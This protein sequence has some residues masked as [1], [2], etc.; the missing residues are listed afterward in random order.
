[1]AF[2]VPA[3]PQTCSTRPAIRVRL[4]CSG[5]VCCSLR[6]VQRW[7]CAPPWPAAAWSHTKPSNLT[8]RSPAVS[9]SYR[10]ATIC[11]FGGVLMTG[12]L[13]ACVH[14]MMHWAAR[15]KRRV[16]G[17]RA[18]PPCCSDEGTAHDMCA[19]PGIVSPASSECGEEHPIALRHHSCAEQ[20][21]QLCSSCAAIDAAYAKEAAASTSEGSQRESEMEMGSL[22]FAGKEVAATPPRISVRR[23]PCC[24]GNPDCCGPT[25]RC[26]N[27][28]GGPAAA[29]IVLGTEAAEVVAVLQSDPHT[30]DLLRMGECCW[31]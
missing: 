20:P 23:Q 8:T 14:A 11:F 29:D 9:A 3:L 18:G 1:M 15:R 24:A 16:D 19:S 17:G 27:T 12:L 7:H 10:L 6:T 13:D 5:L 30:Q 2:P 4:A 22:S 31:P 21:K 26:Y 25:A 28:G